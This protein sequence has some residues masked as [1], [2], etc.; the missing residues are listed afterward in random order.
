MDMFVLGL[1]VVASVLFGVRTYLEKRNDKK[2]LANE[3]RELA[4]SLFLYAEKNHTL[5]GEAK[6]DF[7]VEEI[8][9]RVDGTVLAKV[10]DGVTVRE[11]LQKLYDEVKAKL[12][13]EIK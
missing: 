4:L 3:V 1:V 12:A 6:M 2:A 10:V 8:M 7:V 5:N 11:Y 13:E 9:K